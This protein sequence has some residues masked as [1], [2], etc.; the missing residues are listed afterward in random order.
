[1]GGD[2]E[3]VRVLVWSVVALRTQD[4]HL[5]GNVLAGLDLGLLWAQIQE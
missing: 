5:S 2:G 3:G 4:A 1:M